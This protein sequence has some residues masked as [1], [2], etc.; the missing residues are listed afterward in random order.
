MSLV[1]VGFSVTSSEGPPSPA[2]PASSSASTASAMRQR[3]ALSAALRCCGRGDAA[4]FWDD[5]ESDPSEEEEDADGDA[6]CDELEAWRGASGASVSS[7]PM[8]VPRPRS[9]V[10]AEF[11]WAR[12]QLQL[13]AAQRLEGGGAGGQAAAAPRRQPSPHPQ[14]DCAVGF[15]E[16]ACGADAGPADAA[17]AAVR[18]R[19][20]LSELLKE[21]IC[22]GAFEV[23]S[24]CMACSEDEASVEG[25][26]DGL[27]WDGSW[28]ERCPPGLD[29]PPSRAAE[30]DR[31]SQCSAPIPIPAASY[32]KDE[33]QRAALQ[34]LN[35][36]RAFYQQQVETERM[37][38][39]SMAK[40]K[41]AAAAARGNR[42]PG[43][44][45]A[46]A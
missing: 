11:A 31:S 23:A 5:F 43:R 2:S 45:G 36:K 6:D 44:P 34:K 18:S 10:S 32:F 1:V 8:P 26:G 13:A 3:S 42:P 28:F 14:A 39:R 35:R 29:A 12:H 33:M 24:D 41:Q 40:S 7:A 16:K 4:P 19:S 15:E 30:S 25:G 21:E 37:M 22:S 17:Q 9:R 20:L 27:D 38:A 46:P